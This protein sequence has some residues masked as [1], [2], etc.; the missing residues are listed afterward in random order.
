LSI[1]RACIS[2]PIVLLNLPYIHARNNP[3]ENSSILDLV[4]P[5]G[6]NRCQGRGVGLSSDGGCWGV[7]VKRWWIIS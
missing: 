7:L 5:G 2:T 3:I 1:V 6:M 4:L